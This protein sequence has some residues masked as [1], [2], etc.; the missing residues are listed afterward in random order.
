MKA[1]DNSTV[2]RNGAAM[3]AFFKKE[4]LPKQPGPGDHEHRHT[5]LLVDD[6]AANLENLRAILEKEYRLIEARDGANAL[7]ILQ[8]ADQAARISLIISD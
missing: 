2:L 3:S 5:V 6:E 7:E 4:N 1:Q 8:Q